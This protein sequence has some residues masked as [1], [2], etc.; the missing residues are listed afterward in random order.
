MQTKFAESTAFAKA[1][2]AAQKAA[3]ETKPRFR[4]AEA[5]EMVRLTELKRE[6]LAGDVRLTSRVSW[7]WIVAGNQAEL[8]VRVSGVVW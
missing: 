3:I 1:V 7:Q 8:P 2:V 4:R 6:G 5:K